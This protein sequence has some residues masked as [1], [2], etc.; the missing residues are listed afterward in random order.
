MQDKL[1]K[2]TEL[3]LS[4][5]PVN[6]SFLGRGVPGMAGGSVATQGAFSSGS[7]VTYQLKLKMADFVRSYEAHDTAATQTL[8][9]E[10]E[11]LLMEEQTLSVLD[12]KQTDS[13]IDMLSEI[14]KG[15]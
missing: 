7:D 12:A 13:L 14:V 6:I 1:R 15:K 2:F 5:D 4:I 9:K 11:G 10:I 3:V 8:A